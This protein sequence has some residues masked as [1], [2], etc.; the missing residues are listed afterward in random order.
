MST[1]VGPAARLLDLVPRGARLEEAEF[2]RR[3]VVLNWFA[4]AHLPVILTMAGINHHLHSAMTWVT[5]V[6]IVGLVLAGSQ[7]PQ[8]WRA[9]AV[10]AALTLGCSGVLD[11]GMGST[12]L[13]IWFYVVT[14]AISL[15]QMW[16]PFLVAVVFVGVHHF[17]MT[18]MDPHSVFSDVAAQ[19]APLRYAILHAAFLFTE[20]GWLAYTWRIAENLEAQRGAEFEHSELAR[21]EKEAAERRLADQQEASAQDLAAQL[22]ERQETA[23]RL[24]ES[25]SLLHGIGSRLDVQVNEAGVTL[26]QLRSTIGD[27]DDQSATAAAT[28]RDAAAGSSH[29]TEVIGRLQD[30]LAQVDELAGSIDAVASQTSLLALNATIEAARAG[31]A[32]KGFAVVAGEV[33]ELASETKAATDRIRAVI[34]A[35]RSEVVEASQATLQIHDVIAN[36]VSS[37]ETIADAMRRQSESSVDGQRAVERIAAEATSLRDHLDQLVNR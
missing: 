23:R 33:K 31:E 10:S 27:V 15:Y 36:V 14:V 32:G 35:I 25:I 24:E 2:G 37:Q 26:R 21:R 30:T 18:I 28:A 4:W 16:I 3:H 8:W 7:G 29:V 17:T 9:T 12:H 5:V 11:A 6:S 13:H 19:Q 22:K 1:L 34:D 20:A